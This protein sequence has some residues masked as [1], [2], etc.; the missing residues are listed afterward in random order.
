M[1][2]RYVLWSILTAITLMAGPAFAQQIP[3]C[4]DKEVLNKVM[5]RQNATLLLVNEELARSVVQYQDALVESGQDLE[6]IAETARLLWQ[7]YIEISGEDSNIV[8]LPDD[9]MQIVTEAAMVLDE[10]ILLTP[11]EHERVQRVIRLLK[12]SETDKALA[13]WA[14]FVKN[15]WQD[16]LRGLSPHYGDGDIMA[17][18]FFVFRESIEQTNE[19]KR[20]ILAKLKMWNT[21]S[22]YLSELLRDIR[23]EKRDFATHFRGLE[24][25]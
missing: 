22:E 17:A 15:D 1:R 5:R 25:E 7:T 23:N 16:R 20:Y 21:T 18:L 6:A 12:R 19:D 9:P 10:R 24:C 2:T 13:V 4:E 14:N 3:D 11:S 8:S